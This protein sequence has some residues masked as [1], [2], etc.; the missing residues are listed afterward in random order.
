MTI[1]IFADGVLTHTAPHQR[2][3]GGIKLILL[4]TVIFPVTL[5][6]V[7]PTLSHTTHA[8]IRESSA[9]F[10]KLRLIYIMFAHALCTGNEPTRT[11]PG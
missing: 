8:V 5:A 4:S 6:N 2:T 10:G 1:I 7:R 3:R 11:L 9:V